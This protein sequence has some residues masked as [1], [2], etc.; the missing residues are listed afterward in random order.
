MNGSENYYQLPY[1]KVTVSKVT[2]C[3]FNRKDKPTLS[4][5]VTDHLA[6]QDLSAARTL[7]LTTTQYG[8]I[9][10]PYKYRLTTLI[11][12]PI[13]LTFISVTSLTNI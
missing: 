10:R 11:Y 8:S 3:A 6:P 7:R 5:T 12:L 13:Y 9:I 2:S 4:E 1:S